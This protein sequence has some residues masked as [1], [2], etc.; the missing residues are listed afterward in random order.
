M[1]ITIRTVFSAVVILLSA[2][3][4][5]AETP[6]DQTPTDTVPVLDLGIARGGDKIVGAS[7]FIGGDSSI[8]AGDA[9][10]ADTGLVHRFQDSDWSVK[11]T[12]G[13]AIA[14]IP[15]YWGDFSFKRVP[16]D[17]IAVYNIGHQ[18]VGAG[19]TYHLNPWLDANGHSPDIHYN[20]ALGMLLQYQY[21]MFGVR[22]TY[23]RYKARDTTGNP[24]LDGSSLGLFITIQFAN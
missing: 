12:L 2:G 23:I 6:V 17:M 7:F 19:L 3:T 20:N 8:H 24:R 10:Y 5:W 15:R 9:Y 16:L 11:T 1:S 13:Y 21:R 4:A 18:H 22:Y 14:A